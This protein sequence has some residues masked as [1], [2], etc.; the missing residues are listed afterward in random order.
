MSKLC[1]KS[2]TVRY[3]S[4]VENEYSN[5]KL[6]RIIKKKWEKMGSFIYIY[7][8]LNFQIRLGKNRKQPLKHWVNDH[9]HYKK[10]PIG[11]QID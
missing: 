5:D 6:E 10:W 9:K 8:V 2:W 11:F 4:V 7:G 3:I 1:I